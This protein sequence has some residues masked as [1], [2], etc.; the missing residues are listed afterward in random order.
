MAPF[1]CSHPRPPQSAPP[2]SLLVFSYS[3]LL[4]DQ[5]DFND[6]P[7]SNLS[8]Q[9]VIIAIEPQNPRF[10][11]SFLVPA[12]GRAALLVLLIQVLDFLDGDNALPTFE[13]ESLVDAGAVPGPNNVALG[14]GSVAVAEL[15]RVVIDEDPVQLW[16]IVADGGD[17]AFASAT[18]VLLRVG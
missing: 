6:L 13:G 14:G 5:F 2:P 18:P 12:L 4:P 11:L 3:A 9:G 15:V 8:C 7:T 17:E 16:G 1:L 10:A